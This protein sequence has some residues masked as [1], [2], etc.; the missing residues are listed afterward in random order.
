MKRSYCR[1]VLT[2]GAAL[3]SS[4]GVCQDSKTVELAGLQLTIGMPQQH[5]LEMIVAKSVVTL[6]KLPP[7]LPK[8]LSA[9]DFLLL[10]SGALYFADGALNRVDK[11]VGE[12]PKTGD[13]SSFFQ[14]LYAVLSKLEGQRVTVTTETRRDTRFI[15]EEINIFGTT[16]TVGSKADPLHIIQPI[17]VLQRNTTFDPAMQLGNYIEVF[18]RTDK[19]K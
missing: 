8:D 4:T 5:V 11:K 17:Y 15:A 1:I 14:Q 6:P 12:I 19:S 16:G 9:F 2:L 7:S 10:R 3:F 18:E 13:T